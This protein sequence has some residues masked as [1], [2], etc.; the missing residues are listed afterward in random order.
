[1]LPGGIFARLVIRFSAI[2]SAGTNR[3]SCGIVITPAAMASR[4]PLKAASL[5]VDR[6]LS[7]VGP[8]HAAENVHQSRFAGAILTDKRMH[9]ARRHV[10][11]DVVEPAD[12][13]SR[14]SRL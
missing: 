4:G 9:L 1:M 7:R 2:D 13:T 5:S 14:K 11:M 8:M 10:E 6:D 3:S 12:E